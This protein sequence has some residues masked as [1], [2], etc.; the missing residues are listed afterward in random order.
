MSCL[1]AN[2]RPESIPITPDNNGVSF[3]G[4]GVVMVGGPA[5]KFQDIAK[6][7]ITQ[8]GA[9]SVIPSYGSDLPKIKA[10]PANDDVGTQV[11]DSVVAA[12]SFLVQVETSPL[13]DE[14]IKSIQAL[15]VQVPSRNSGSLA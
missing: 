2:K 12:L 4:G 1:L 9:D 7:L 11:S 8:M 13:P 14:N 6:I 5:R 3:A 15:S 10:Q